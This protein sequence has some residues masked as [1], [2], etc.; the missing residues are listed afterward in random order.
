MLRRIDQEA[1]PGTLDVVAVSAAR[2]EASPPQPSL[3]ARWDAVLAR[4]PS[5]WSDLLCELELD[6]SADLERAAVLVGSL[7]PLQTGAGRPCFRFRVA[8]TR[9]YGTAPAMARRCLERLDGEEIGADVR[10]L[11]ALSDS[12]PVQTQGPVWHVGGRSV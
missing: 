4:L 9:G 10:V 12:R 3:A 6:S 2:P 1:I 8:H 11:Q 5:D 7:N